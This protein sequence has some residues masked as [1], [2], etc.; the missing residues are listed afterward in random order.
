MALSD[1]LHPT[2]SELAIQ[3]CVKILG[4]RSGRH[5]CSDLMIEQSL[6]LP[7]DFRCTLAVLG[8]AACMHLKGASAEVSLLRRDLP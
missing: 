2:N 3:Q 1:G 4:S 6:R 7:I 8:C 5:F